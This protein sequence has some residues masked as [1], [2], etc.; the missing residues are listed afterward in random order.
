MIWKMGQRRFLRNRVGHHPWAWNISK[1]DK[2][3][4]RSRV[5]AV[6]PTQTVEMRK[7]A[8]SHMEEPSR[9]SYLAAAFKRTIEVSK[10]L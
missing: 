6:E 10:S 9:S 4:F 5:L 8:T 1:I 7:P 2:G 3:L